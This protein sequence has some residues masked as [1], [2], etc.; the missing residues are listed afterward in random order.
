MME[1]AQEFVIE[2]S[3]WMQIDGAP[4]FLPPSL[5]LSFL[6][7]FIFHTISTCSVLQ[8]IFSGF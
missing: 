8:S 1:D 7:I 3:P 5:P 2:S 6:S 4:S